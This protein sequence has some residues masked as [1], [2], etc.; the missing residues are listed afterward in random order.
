MDNLL[1]EL[2]R[3][4]GMLCALRFRVEKSGVDEK[5]TAEG[6]SEIAAIAGRLL[7]G[8]ESGRGRLPSRNV[9][10]KK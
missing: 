6:V 1:S 10:G 2:D 5:A 7:D 4:I 9:F 8:N 3:T